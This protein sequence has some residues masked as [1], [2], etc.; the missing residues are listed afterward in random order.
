MLHIDLD[1]LCSTSL[2]AFSVGTT[3]PR[4]NTV[5]GDQIVHEPMLE[6]N[7]SDNLQIAIFVGLLVFACPSLTVAW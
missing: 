1:M 7:G 5:P 2:F 3:C 4:R 6:L